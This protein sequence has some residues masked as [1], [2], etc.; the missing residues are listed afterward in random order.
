MLHPKDSSEFPLATVTIQGLT[1][2][3]DGYASLK[4]IEDHPLVAGSFSKLKNQDT[5]TVPFALPGERVTINVRSKS[6]FE[7][8]GHLV[9]V[10]EP[11]LDR[12]NAPCEH[13]RTCG[14]CNLQHYSSR[15]YKTFKANLV[16]QAFAKNDLDPSLIADPIIIG[17]GNRRR[18]DFMARKWDG[19]IKMGFHEAFSKKPFNVLSCPLIHPDM[20]KIF[21]DLREVLIPLLDLERIIHVFMTRAQNGL[22][23]L[24]A[25]FKSPLPDQSLKTLTTFAKNHELIKLSYKVKKKEICLYK[26]ETPS[27]RFGKHD[28]PVTAF[29]FLQATAQSDTIFSDFLNQYLESKSPLKIADLFCGRGTLSLNLTQQG[30]IVHGFECDGQALE[31]LKSVSEPNLSVHTRN[32][33]ESPLDSSEL[34]S[35]DAI[36]MNPPR[37]GAESQT[38]AITNSQVSKLIYIS[39]N[40]DS[41]ARDAKELISKGFGLKTVV[42]VDQFMWTP[43][44]EVMAYFERS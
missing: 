28:V 37:A 39:C 29:G 18:I 31:A 20:P 41:F 44:I 42:P 4:D 5:I 9:E 14:G 30:H 27:V 40:A 16:K 34:S 7:L 11:S 17:P 3:G 13:F 6:R 25:G 36:V 10:L 43:H 21:S 8:V 33:F 32:L 26:K 15:S 12:I 23:I 1:P 35:F 19:Q 22:D 38:V 24:L 2:R